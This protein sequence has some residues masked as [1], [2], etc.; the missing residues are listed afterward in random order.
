MHCSSEGTTNSAW[1][2]GL[3]TCTCK[4]GNDCGYC[5]A[6]AMYVSSAWC[7]VVKTPSAAVQTR[8]PRWLRWC[9]TRHISHSATAGLGAAVA[10]SENSM[11]SMHWNF[12]DLKD[13]VISNLS[14]YCRTSA[15]IPQLSQVMLPYFVRRLALA[16]ASATGRQA[17]IVM[18][19]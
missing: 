17:I 8:M 10:G 13:V 19:K 6:R 12:K 1:G 7:A 5:C 3:T 11:E 16:Q 4:A 2:A 9:Q 18:H 14:S 15:C